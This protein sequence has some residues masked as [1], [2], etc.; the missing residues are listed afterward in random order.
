MLNQKQKVSV[1]Y[2]K[3]DPNRCLNG[4]CLSVVECPRKV[5]K[6]EDPYDPPYIVSG[7]CQECS[8]CVEVCITGAVKMLQT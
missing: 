4:V 3:C 5:F 8:K 2:K 1:D 6:Q 7:F